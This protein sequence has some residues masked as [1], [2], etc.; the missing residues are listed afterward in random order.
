MGLLLVVLYFVYL[1]LD[2]REKKMVYKIIRL[3]ICENYLKKLMLI[4]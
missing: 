2:F 3:R 4:K 1:I